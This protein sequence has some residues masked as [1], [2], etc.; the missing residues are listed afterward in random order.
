MAISL[1]TAARNARLTALI[2][3]IDAGSGPG[4]LSI[5]SG[6]RPATGGA[7]TTLLAELTLSDPCGTVSGGVLTFNAITQDSSANAS[8]T[9]SWARI[10]DSTGT[11]VLDLGVGTAGS[12]QEII[13]NTT[14]IVAG[15]PVGITSASLTEGNP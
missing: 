12:G 13:L 3:A 14:T 1:S 2:T 4:V 10:V 7:T 11:H 6:T 5:Y 8:G 9:A 15:G